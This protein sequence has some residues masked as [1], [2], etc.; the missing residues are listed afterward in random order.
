MQ[1]E[2]V[3]KFE[4]NVDQAASVLFGVA[5][6]YSAFLC[7]KAGDRLGPLAIAALAG[8]VA[9]ITYLLSYRFLGAIKPPARAIPVRAFRLNEVEPLEVEEFR[10]LEP[11]HATGLLAAPD[12]FDRDELLLTNPVDVPI[13]EPGELLLTENYEAQEAEKARPAEGSEMT[14]E[15]ASEPEELELS[16]SAETDASI[17][18]EDLVLD[19]LADFGPNSRVVRLFD[20]AA[21]PRPGQIA[22]RV[23]Q[24]LQG[25]PEQMQSAEAARA[26]QDALAELRRAIPNRL[27]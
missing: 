8:A 13:S 2:F 4:K 9:L 24:D 15:Q 25:E 14:P 5:C 23:D 3:N 20:P 6:G 16:Q 19:D 26:L 18:N 21:M 27:R 10:A 17:S 1:A 11:G 7:L 22:S 12:M